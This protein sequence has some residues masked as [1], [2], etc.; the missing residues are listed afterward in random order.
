MPE[1]TR[2]TSRDNRRLVDVRKIRDGKETK[3]IFVEGARLA[4]EVLCSEL[5]LTDCIVSTSFL[6]G[7]RSVSILR[8]LS[9]RNV[10]IIETPD[11]LFSTLA[12]TVNSQG[13]ILVAKRPETGRDQLKVDDPTKD[14]TLF[15]FLRETNDPSNLGAVLRTA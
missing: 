6:E 4:E 8:D 1:I 5:D 14:F 10:P 13:V 11:R 9:G 15:V 12:D 7:D 3:S 2:I